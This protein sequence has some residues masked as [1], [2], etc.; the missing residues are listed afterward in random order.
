METIRIGA[1]PLVTSRICLGTWAIGGWMWG[2]SDEAEAV[3]TIQA[4]VDRGIT[5]IDTAPIYGF[6]RAEEIVG[7]ALAEGG[8]RQ[9]VL[10]ATK[11]GMVWEQGGIHRDSSP[12][13]I[14]YEVAQSLRR[15]R[16]DHIDLYQIHWP[17][18]LVPIEDTAQAMD[19]LFRQETIRAIGVSNYAPGQMEAFAQVA[20]LHAVQPPYNVFERAIEADVLPYAEQRGLTVLAYGALCRGLLTGRISEQ[21]RFGGDDLRRNDPK[22]QPPRRAQYLAAVRELDDYARRR[23]RKTVLALAIRWV[24]DRGQTVALWGARRPAQLDAVD[25]VFGWQ[26]DRQALQDIDHILQRTIHDPVGP[27]FMAPPTGVP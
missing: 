2:G 6:G 26:L 20:P 24:L 23:W 13:R 21:T 4:A 1:S 10:I 7:K 12:E 15:L 5:M 22:F 9:R 19:R 14:A 16:T 27:E 3:A 17:D 25:Q 18:P 8:R 11:V